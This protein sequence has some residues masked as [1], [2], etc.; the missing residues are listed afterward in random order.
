MTQLTFVNL[1]ESFRL[2]ERKLSLILV[3]TGLTLSLFRLLHRIALHMPISASKLSQELGIAKPSVTSQLR[4]LEKAGLVIISSNPDDK[5]S[6]FISLSET[7]KVRFRIVCENIA[8]LE[9]KSGKKL[10]SRLET[11]IQQVTESMS[12]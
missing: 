5:R 12:K 10:L 3:E 9:E 4:E 8:L 7:G 2:I 11:L 6:I 1:I